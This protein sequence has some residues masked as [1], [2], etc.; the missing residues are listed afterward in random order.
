MEYSFGS[1][2]TAENIPRNFLVLLFWN[3]SASQEHPVVHGA[4]HVCFVYRRLPAH[5]IPF[6]L[7]SIRDKSIKT[8]LGGGGQDGGIRQEKAFR[9]SEDFCGSAKRCSM[10]IHRCAHRALSQRTGI[11]R[12]L[13]INSIPIS[14]QRV[15]QDPPQ[16]NS[17]RSKSHQH[18]TGQEATSRNG[19][20][21]C[22][23]NIYYKK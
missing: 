14:Q 22:L 19:T 11:N 8:I 6:L 7:I 15:G 3:C 18:Q 17:E 2:W 10:P 1:L 12:P 5:S 20:R 16:H 21:A 23:R 4:E 9:R 13:F